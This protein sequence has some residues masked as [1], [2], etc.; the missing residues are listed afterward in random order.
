MKQYLL[1]IVFAIA[2][3]LMWTTMF[4]I[5]WDVPFKNSIPI[6]VILTVLTIF[7]YWGINK[8]ESNS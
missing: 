1:I 2:M 5:S 3:C 8:D 7:G 4:S 6:G